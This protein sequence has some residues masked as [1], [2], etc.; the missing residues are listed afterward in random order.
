MGRRE[1]PR[2]GALLRRAGVRC[3]SGP[4][5]V[6]RTMSA[7]PPE[8]A[9]RPAASADADALA[10]GVIDGLA[11]YPAFAPDGW[12]PPRLA[13]EAAHTR[14]ALADPD[15]WCLVAESGGR[16][17]GQISLVPA[18]SGPRPAADATLAHVRNLFVDRDHRGTGLAR[19]LDA[20]AGDAARV[21]GFTTMRLFVAA[22]QTR[23]R[24]FYERAGWAP[25]SEPFFDP[26]PGLAMVEYRR[27]VLQ[28][29]DDGG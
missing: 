29:A 5:R 23:A 2:P 13:D 7:P 11:D 9:L 15:A 17:V 1:I 21:R 3:R 8:Y 16:I 6:A 19:V 28:R 14:R 25:V 22:G 20:A 4:V 26:V 12:T 18:T 10:R 24:A 27:A